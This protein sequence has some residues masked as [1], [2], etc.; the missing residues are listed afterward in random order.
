MKKFLFAV[1]LFSFVVTPVFAEVNTDRHAQAVG[2]AEGGGGSQVVDNGNPETPSER[3]GGGG[4]LSKAE[5]LERAQLRQYLELLQIYYG[6]LLI[7]LS[8]VNG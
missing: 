8:Q 6:L 4:G 7:Q 5:K 3:R 1:L 2:G